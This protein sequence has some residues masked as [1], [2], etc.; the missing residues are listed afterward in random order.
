MF[1]KVYTIQKVLEKLEDFAHNVFALSLGSSW[2]LIP[3]SVPLLQHFLIKITS[4]LSVLAMMATD[5]VLDCSFPAVSKHVLHL[6]VI[7]GNYQV[8]DFSKLCAVLLNSF[9]ILF[10]LGHHT[11]LAPQKCCVYHF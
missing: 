1:A 4:A 3:P 10:K 7:G 5:E 11:F 2:F 6:Q 8:S 9:G